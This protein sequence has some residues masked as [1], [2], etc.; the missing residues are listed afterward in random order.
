MGVMRQVYA[1]EGLRGLFVGVGPRAGRS[2][3]ACAI[4]VACYELLKSWL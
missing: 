1:E 2:A 3:P 4:V